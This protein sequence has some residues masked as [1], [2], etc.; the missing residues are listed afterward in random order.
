MTSGSA[1]PDSRA[2][3]PRRSGANRTSAGSAVVRARKPPTR[4]N[5]VPYKGY[6]QSIRLIVLMIGEY[7]IFHTMYM[8]HVAP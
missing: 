1:A 7:C 8:V 2:P 5:Y 6:P 3:S 4:A